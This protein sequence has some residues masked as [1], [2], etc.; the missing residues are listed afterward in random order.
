MTP[1][2]IGNFLSTQMLLPSSSDDKISQSIKFV[3][4]MF[5]VTNLCCLVKGATEQLMMDS[6]ALS[7]GHRSILR[8]KQY[9]HFDR[10]FYHF[11]L[12]DESGKGRVST[13]LRIFIY[14]FAL[15]HLV[16]IIGVYRC[17]RM[18]C[19]VLAQLRVHQCTATHDFQKMIY[20]HL[21]MYAKYF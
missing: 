21:K 14:L 5:N 6:S 3:N 18:E 19:D 16:V 12:S 9:L 10:N 8:P 20:R 1:C 4:N 11:T 17:C 7:S 13:L 15:P 2:C